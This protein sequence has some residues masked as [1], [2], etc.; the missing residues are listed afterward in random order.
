[1]CGLD[2]LTCAVLVGSDSCNIEIA[3]LCILTQGILVFL[4]FVCW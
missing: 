4:I 2:G 3:V 1:M